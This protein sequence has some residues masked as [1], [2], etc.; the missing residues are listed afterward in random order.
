MTQ[1]WVFPVENQLFEW[2]TKVFFSGPDQ[3]TKE[4]IQNRCGSRIKEA[5][6]NLLHA[7]YISKGL[8]DYSS[9][10][11]LAPFAYKRHVSHD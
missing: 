7:R 11:S 5:F 3:I 10:H 8:L 2:H 1:A 9:K 6:Q 4:D